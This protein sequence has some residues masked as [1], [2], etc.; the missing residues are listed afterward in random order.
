MIAETVSVRGN[1]N[2]HDIAKAP[3]RKEQL[4]ELTDQLLN[5]KCLLRCAGY[6]CKS[7]Q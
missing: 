1:F 7:A 2:P 5:K 6:G 3:H 4:T